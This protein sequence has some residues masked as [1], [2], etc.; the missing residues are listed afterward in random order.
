MFLPTGKV[1]SV[2]LF[3]SSKGIDCPKFSSSILADY[4]FSRTSK[5]GRECARWKRSPLTMFLPSYIVASLIPQQ[6]QAC[7]FLESLRSL[8]G[9]LTGHTHHR[10][11]LHA[12]E[13]G[14]SLVA[15]KPRTFQEKHGKNMENYDITSASLAIGTSSIGF[16]EKFAKSSPR[17]PGLR[18]IWLWHHDP[19]VEL[20][21][22]TALPTS[23]ETC[24]THGSQKSQ[25]CYP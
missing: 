25:T 3:L 1:Q 23:C 16:I 8:P 6:V 4:E 7:I 21:S 9:V 22:F 15:W 17:T 5:D 20:I 2:N 24:E 18:F 13:A 19:F 12:P 14:D 10:S 11:G